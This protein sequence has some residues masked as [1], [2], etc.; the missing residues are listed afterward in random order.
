MTTEAWT[1]RAEAARLPETPGTARGTN[2]TTMPEAIATTKKTASGLG[3]VGVRKAASTPTDLS[4]GGA[5][6]GRPRTMG[7][8]IR[9]AKPPATKTGAYPK[10]LASET[11]SGS[12]TTKGAPTATP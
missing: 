8:P 3:R 9:A 6:S 10:L 5:F 4:A 1:K 12:A 11:P 7:T 2:V